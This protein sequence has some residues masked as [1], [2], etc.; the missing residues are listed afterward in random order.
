VLRVKVAIFTGTIVLGQKEYDVRRAYIL[1]RLKYLS[2]YNF[3]L[4]LV[5]PE[6]GSDENKTYNHTKYNLYTY[7]FKNRNGFKSLSAMVFS[8]PGL[9][10]LDCDLIHCYSH[11]AALIAILAN[12]IRKSK[13]PIL[14]EPMGLAEEEDRLNK[15][16]SIKISLLMR[17]NKLIEKTIFKESYGIIVYTHALKKYISKKF[18]VDENRIYIV[19][20]GVNLNISYKPDKTERHNIFSKLNI[21]DNNKIVMYVG[22]LSELHGTPHLM[23]AIKEVTIRRRDTTFIILGSGILE[24]NVNKFIS[25]NKL[26]NVF[27]PGL[28]SSKEIPFYLS[29]ADVLVIPHS[30]CLQTE[31]DQPTKLF[32]YLSSGK[33]I[34]SFDLKAIAEVVGENAILVKPDSSK[35][36]AE[37][38]LTLLN[39]ERLAKELGEK[40]KEIVKKYSWEES[41]R[42]QYEAYKNLYHQIYNSDQHAG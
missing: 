30:R 7:K 21:R 42:Q 13:N 18:H 25:I 39:N 8:I 37:G 15:K 3:N 26:T 22:S 36:L 40:G 11:Q 34:V 17:F 4:C 16:S 41:A 28:I 24:K 20:H 38:I 5:T 6:T 10:R 33:P 29:I 19:P 32:E 9:V 27:Y 14:F 35:A 2:N 31:L 12:F 1:E 23:E